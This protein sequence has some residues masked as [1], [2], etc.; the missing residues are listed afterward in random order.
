M[1][2]GSFNNAGMISINEFDIKASEWDKNPVHWE[3][4]Y[5]IAGEIIKQIPMSQAF[6][7][8]EFGAG[9]G[10]LSFLLREQL[11]EIILMDSSREMIRMINDKIKVAGVTNLKSLF[12]DLEN[13][14]YTGGKF[15]FIF[16]Q[17]A[18]HHV[19]DVEKILRKFHG[20]INPGGYL[21]IADLYPED[22]SFH[23]NGFTGHRGFDVDEFARTLFRIGFS[24]IS[25][26]E[27]FTVKREIPGNITRQYPVFLITANRR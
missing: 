3:R 26:R 22:G 15:D 2:S 16:T 18:L 24:E 17:M 9:T 23:G 7:A 8:L 13:S 1:L 20:L 12:F 25:H 14:D 19:V 27:C 10:I 5:A 6:T 21:A 11:K 4:S